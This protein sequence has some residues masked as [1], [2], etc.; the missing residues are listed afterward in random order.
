MDVVAIGIRRVLAAAADDEAAYAEG[1]TG[2]PRT[3]G[4]MSKLSKISMSAVGQAAA[5][6]QHS[7][8][9]GGS[10]RVDETERGQ[11]ERRSDHQDACARTR[12][13]HRLTWSPCLLQ[14][15]SL[16]V[17]S[18]GAW[19][20]H[21]PTY[22][23]SPVVLTSPFVDTQ[24]SPMGV[25]LP[26]IRS[27]GTW[28]RAAQQRSRH[29]ITQPESTG[30]QCSTGSKRGH[31]QQTRRSEPQGH[32][33]TGRDQTTARQAPSSAQDRRLLRHLIS[34]AACILLT[35][36]HAHLVYTGPCCPS[37]Y[38]RLST[39]V[40]PLCCVTTATHVAHVTSA[41]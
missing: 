22:P 39:R 29:A 21:A 13:R 28:V 19:H 24:T 20:T 41:V 15:A 9:G 5:H 14:R 40:V 11:Q 34:L 4:M 7:G 37:A 2:K 6:A 23:H 12:I 18:F 26:A 10:S 35:V 17:T 36:A 32:A 30:P 38:L 33:H 27:G 3:M 16:L 25:F 31:L 1:C 8:T